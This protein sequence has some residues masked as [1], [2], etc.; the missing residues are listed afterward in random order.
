[1]FNT[2]PVIRFSLLVGFGA[3]VPFNGI[4]ARLSDTVVN[5]PTDVYQWCRAI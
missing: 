2:L 5:R 3:G 4:D 1:M